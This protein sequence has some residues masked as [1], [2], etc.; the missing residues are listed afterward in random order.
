MALAVPPGESRTGESRSESRIENE[1]FH[2]P[3]TA[4]RARLAVVIVNFCQWKNTYRLV[5]QL[6]R[7]D[8]FRSGEAEIVI[9][10]NAS[11]EDVTANRLRRL[12]G[13]RIIFNSRNEGFAAAVNRGAALNPAEWILLLNPD[14]EVPEF[15]LDDALTVAEA[16]GAGDSRTGVIGFRLTDADGS[17]Q[18]SAGPFPTFRSTVLGLL[19]PRSRRKCRHLAGR[20]PRTV[21]W[22]TGGCL[23]VRRE[24]FRELGGLDERFF[25]YY[26]DVDFCRR[27]SDAG[28]TVWHEPS[29]S[30]VHRSPLHGRPVP[31]PL[32][33]MI[34]H[35]LLAYADRHWGR[36]SQR[37]IRILIRCEAIGRGLVARCRGDALAAEYH[38]E[39]INLVR[40]RVRRER[41]LHAAEQLRPIAASHDAR[42]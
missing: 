27:V 29:L 5:H 35:A 23:L 33:L 14:V 38:R 13:V 37:A 36:W 10:D 2:A 17:P 20:A 6:R 16:I 39:L 41:I 42:P 18:A 40:S 32:R 15:F 19:R 7:S 31:A 24:C 34:R 26:E 3:Q 21:D 4:V 25:L 30:V 11:T 8:V 12:D 28:R 9:V 1:P 22:V